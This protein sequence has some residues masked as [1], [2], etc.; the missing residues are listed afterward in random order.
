MTIANA[1]WD[2]QAVTGGQV[3][4]RP[5]LRRSGPTSSSGSRCRGRG[6][7][8]A[9]GSWCS[10]VRAIWDTWQHGTPLD[11]EG[12]FYTHTRMV[13]AFDPG[14][15]EH[16]P[17]PILVGAVG[18]R[19]TAVAGEVADG[20]LVHPVNTRRSLLELTMPALAEGAGSGRADGRGRSNWCA[21]RSW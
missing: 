11:F 16:G 17:P 7:R 6:R 10:G 15:S 21:S 12:E 1:G 9:C 2:L 4:P 8:I 3:H 13:P 5:R 19:M 20:L 18:P 14:P